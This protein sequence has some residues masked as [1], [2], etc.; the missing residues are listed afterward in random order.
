MRRPQ[1][2]KKSPTCFDVCSVMSKQVGDFLKFLW[3]FNKTGY[4]IFRISGPPK[5]SRPSGKPGLPGSPGPS[6]QYK[7][8][9]RAPRVPRTPRI[10]RT[11]RTPRT[12][13]TPRIA[14]VSRITR[15]SRDSLTFEACSDHGIERSF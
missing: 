1:N 10:P 3:P 11:P 6:I 8:D 9:P 2:L 12:S 4:R 5:S 13:R 15:T 14:G 7:Q